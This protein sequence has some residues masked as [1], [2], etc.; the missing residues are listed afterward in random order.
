ME[1]AWLELHKNACANQHE[2]EDEGADDGDNDD[3]S[4]D[5][6]HCGVATRYHSRKVT[7]VS[8]WAHLGLTQTRPWWDKRECNCKVR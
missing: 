7:L 1:Y 2:D 3:G 6:R 4:S 5:G 8:L